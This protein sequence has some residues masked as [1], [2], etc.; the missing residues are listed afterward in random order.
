MPVLVSN[1]DETCAML[2][3]IPS[4]SGST[5]PLT[6]KITV[7]APLQSAGLPAGRSTETLLMLPAIGEPGLVE[8]AGQAVPTPCATSQY[9]LAPV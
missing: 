9:Q 2:L 5:V 6:W 3:R 1:G 8:P 7:P 4:A